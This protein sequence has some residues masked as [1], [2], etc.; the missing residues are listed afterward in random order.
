MS[1]L[2]TVLFVFCPCALSSIIQR[3][4]MHG[5]ILLVFNKG[6]VWIGVCL[7]IVGCV[8]VCVNVGCECVC[9]CACTLVCVCVC[10]CVLLT[11][12]LCKRNARV[13]AD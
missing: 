4:A 12:D 13:C 11:L 7:R 5:F 1:M 6:D 8:S 3:T 10:V 9:V 2:S